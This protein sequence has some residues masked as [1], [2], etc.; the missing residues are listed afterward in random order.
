MNLGHELQLRDWTYLWQRLSHV[1]YA[2]ARRAVAAGLGSARTPEQQ[3]CLCAIVSAKRCPVSQL[4]MR[5]S[6][7]SFAESLRRTV[8]IGRTPWQVFVSLAVTDVGPPHL[9]MRRYA[10][11]KDISGALRVR[12]GGATSF[13]LRDAGK[14][15]INHF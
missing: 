3:S 2:R 15:Y 11:T 1:V 4:A 9:G 10:P 8:W 5:F 12:E 6:P 14:T 7:L 13:G